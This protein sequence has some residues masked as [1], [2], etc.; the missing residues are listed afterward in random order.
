[1][2]EPIPPLAEVFAGLSDWRESS[3]KRYE[4]GSVLTLAFLALLSGENSVRGIARWVKEQ[5]WRVSRALGLK[6]QRVPGYE[7]IRTVLRD[8]DI[9][10]L[11]AD[12]QR[13]A[14]QVAE[15]YQVTPWPGVALDGKTL[16][17]SREGEQAAVPLLSAFVHELEL[18]VGQQ[19]VGSKTNEIPIARQVLEKLTLEGV[20]I[21]CDALH[22]QR[23]TAALIVE[24][25]GPI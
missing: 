24:K 10:E 13:W 14:G 16:R 6:K 17:G 12:L 21:T 1:M 4:L 2:Q 22:T 15:V 7:T 20:L 9:A 25:G 8:L 5:R 3:G 19:A 11:E 23:E 18:V